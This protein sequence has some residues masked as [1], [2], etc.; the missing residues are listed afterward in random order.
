MIVHFKPM[1]V[2]F[3]RLLVLVWAVALAGCAPEEGSREQMVNLQQ[4]KDDPETQLANLSAAL[5]RTKQDGSLYMRRAMLFLQKGELEK[6]LADANAA[7]RL[8]Q[9]EAGSLFVKAQVLRAMGR[10]QEALPLAVQAERTGYPST[11]LYVLLSDLYLQRRQFDEAKMNL[12][13]AQELSPRNEYVF[14]YKGRLAEA[15]GDTA[16]ALKNYRRALQLAPDFV[17]PRRELAGV[18]VRQ[19]RYA[20][21]RPHLRKALQAAPRDGLLWLYQGS[22]YRQEHQQDSALR[23]FGRAVAL[24]D[25]LQQAHYWL[26]LQ[27]H[28]RANN[29]AA[30]LHLEKAQQAYEN[31]PKYLSTLASAYE[32]TGQNARSLATYQR[33]VAIEPKATY[34]YQAISRLKNKLAKPMPAPTPVAQEQIE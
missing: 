10:R 21:A 30:L 19:E 25:T 14:Y 9:N 24:N 6:A 2:H 18:L 13:K 8:T 27:Q 26:G 22:V 7:L 29:E 23:A 3:F 16:N 11:S 15:V 20:E 31:V 17:E 5:M 4:V 28:A 34:A 32:R 1:I 12:R 33:L